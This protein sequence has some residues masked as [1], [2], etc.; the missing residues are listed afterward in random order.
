MKKNIVSLIAG[1]ILAFTVSLFIHK[2][3]INNL[4]F[5]MGVYDMPG[6]EKAIEDTLKLFNR[7]FATFFNTGGRLEGLNEFPAANLIKRR[8]FQDINKWNKENSVLV[9][10]KDLFE[11]ISLEILA[12]IRAVAVAKEVWF[13]NVKDRET[14]KNLSAV[15][16]NPIK[17]RYILKKIDGSW[18]VIEYEVFGKDDDIPPLITG[19]VWL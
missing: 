10:D 16:A 17:I 3:G 19:R 11:I 13:L 5:H 12:P 6:E 1:I 4:F 15:K 14:R 8:I 9:Y 2:N 7:H 18:R